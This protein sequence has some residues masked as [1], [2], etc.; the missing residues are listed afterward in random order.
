MLPKKKRKKKNREQYIIVV[1]SKI[2]IRFG[3]EIKYL[4]IWMT[5]NQTIH[6]IKYLVSEDLETNELFW[7]T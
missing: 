5:F 6:L 4:L 2:G 7:W 1:G 3:I